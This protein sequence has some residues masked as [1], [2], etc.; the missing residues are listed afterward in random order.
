MLLTLKC[1]MYNQQTME[2][3]LERE[4]MNTTTKTWVAYA[5]HLACGWHSR[6]IISPRITS[7]TF[8]QVGVCSCFINEISQQ[9]GWLSALVI[10]VFQSESAPSFHTSTKRPFHVLAHVPSTSSSAVSTNSETSRFSV[11]YR[12]LSLT[13][14]RSLHVYVARPN[15]QNKSIMFY[16]LSLINASA[17]YQQSPK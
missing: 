6:C 10:F 7:C 4:P 12:R 15:N 17:T 5:P 14:Q 3:V 11:G 9:A 2:L 16:E 1:L 13:T 8:T